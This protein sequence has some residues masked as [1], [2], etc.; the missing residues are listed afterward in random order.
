[1][2]KKK[3]RTSLILIIVA[4]LL[5]ICSLSW[6]L[7]QVFEGEKP[8]IILEPLPAFV[9]KPQTF[10]L[11]LIDKKRGL[12]NFAV[13]V[14]QGNKKITI[15]KKDFP[16]KDIMNREGC[17]EFELKFSLDPERLDLTQ[18]EASLIVSVRD[19]SM[20]SGGDGNLSVVTHRFIMDTVPP[21]LR[22]ISRLHYISVGGTGLVVYQVS[23]DTVKSGVFVS[24]LFFPGFKA[25]KGSKDGFNV[26]YFTIPYY[27]RLPVDI[28]LWAKDRAD[29]ESI[30][31]FYYR[32]RR[33]PVHKSR[34][35][36]SNRF[37]NR[38][39]PWFSFYKF[40]PGL[41]NVEKFIEINSKLRKQNT[42]FFYSLRTKT[43][44]D[45]LW[46]GSVWLRLKN[47]A[48]MAR[49]G[50]RRTY[51]YKGQKIGSAVHLGVD[52]ASL[53]NSEV[54]AANN[55]RVLFA[56]PVGIYGMTVVLDHGQGLA[57]SYS[58][59]SKISVKTGQTVSKGEIIAYTGQTG[60]AGGDHLHFGVMVNG[61][62]VNPV[63]WWDAHWVRDN[64]A[65]KLLLIKK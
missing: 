23:S 42:A 11:H 27:I 30:G 50:D 38:V 21:A 57:S 49:F 32:I 17:H 65:R 8:Q 22:V 16:F 52:L 2:R 56:G 9:S 29:N 6:F 10:T 44:P 48:T 46:D 59:L 37:L 58:H 24:S 61:I 33:R 45:Q 19:Y 40:S 35:N 64:I 54:Q 13:Y 39:L 14:T 60:L 41:S 12:R 26:C 20:R 3:N 34:L 15:S 25:D 62:F 18:G 31:R 1:M 28:H 5:I 55:G 43:S 4:V 53:A 47:A 63:E 36:I 7:F 51:Y